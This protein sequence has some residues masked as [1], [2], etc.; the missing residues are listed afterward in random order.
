MHWER[1][2]FGE[3]RKVKLPKKTDRFTVGC[4]FT[5]DTGPNGD[6]VE[7]DFKVSTCQFSHL[8]SLDIALLALLRIRRSE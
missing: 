4:L 8:R 5:A 3:S 6:E 2:M 1:R 7:E